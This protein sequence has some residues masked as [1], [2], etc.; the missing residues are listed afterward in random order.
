M[1]EFSK[2]VHD[3]HLRHFG[4]NVLIL[5]ERE[6]I[7]DEPGSDSD[8]IEVDA[9]EVDASAP[10]SSEEGKGPTTVTFKCIRVL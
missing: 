1:E 10:P 7:Q 9:I 3:K 6:I 8:T 2:A 5:W 4:D